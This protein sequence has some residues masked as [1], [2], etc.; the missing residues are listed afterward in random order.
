[1]KNDK[2]VVAI[3]Y[4]FDNTLSTTDMQE[5]DFIPRLGM[6]SDDFWAEANGYAKQHHMDGI[7][8]VMYM[9]MQK[10]KGTDLCTRSS[11]KDCGKNVRFYNG[12]ETWFD[13]INDFAA[14]QGVQVEHYIISS[15]IKP[16]IEGSKIGKYFKEIYACDYVYDQHGY[17]LWPSIA[18]NYTSKVQFLYRIHK[19]I[20]DVSEDDKLNGFT[21]EEEKHVSFA[22]MVYIGDGMT[23]IPCM[24]LTR[25]NG[26]HSIGVYRPQV[27]NQYLI[28]DDRVDFLVPADYSAG[29]EIEQIMK[30]IILKLNAESQLERI[31]KQHAQR[32][33]VQEQKTEELL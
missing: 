32:I 16:M 20:F 24:K 19:G 2:T 27:G 25:Q 29:S 21:P 13:R 14:E 11:L 10:S 23:D 28:K 1:M 8:A 3:M 30:T 18:V 22:N 26:G 31:T 5:F 17:P 15:G 9:M 7:L 33:L 12:V 4:D 6:T